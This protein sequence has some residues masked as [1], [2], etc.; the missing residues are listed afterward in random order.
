M[1]KAHL[2][3]LSRANPA[4]YDAARDIIIRTANDPSLLGASVH[5][6]IIGKISKR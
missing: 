4:A 3:E 2:D 1:N 5:L 6:L